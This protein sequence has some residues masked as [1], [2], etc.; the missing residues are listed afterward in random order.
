LSF[1]AASPDGS[2]WGLGAGSGD[3]LIYHYVSGSWTYVQGAASRLA[4]GPDGTPWAVTAAGNIY[5]YQNGTWNGIAGGASDIS[6]GADSSVY[7]VSNQGGGQYGYGIWHFAG[8]TWTQL[9]G[10]GVRVAASWDTG[11]YAGG[12]APGGFYLLNALGEIYYYTAANAYVQQPGT[13]SAIAPTTI[14]G[15]FSLSYPADTSGNGNAISYR[16]VATGTSVTQPGAAFGVSTNTNYAY[17]VGQGNV[18]YQSSVTPNPVTVPIIWDDSRRELESVATSSGGPRLTVLQGTSNTLTVYCTNCYDGGVGGLG[19]PFSVNWFSYGAP[20]GIAV[21]FQPAQTTGASASSMF[22]TA[23]WSAPPGNYN[24]TYYVCRV[25]I[26][27]VCSDYTVVDLIVLAAV[28]GPTG[29]QIPPAIWNQANA[30]RCQPG[31]GSLGNGCAIAVNKVLY[32]ALGHTI[33]TSNNDTS[34]LCHTTLQHP[35]FCQQSWV[36]DV[37][38]WGLAK[39]YLRQVAEQDAR[40]GDLTVQDGTRPAEGMQHI[41]FCESQFCQ[42]ALSNSGSSGTLCNSTGPGF[43]T[44]EP[45]GWLPWGLGPAAYRVL[46]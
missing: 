4:V 32:K 11:T 45:G 17:V 15:Y 37:I 24:F 5:Y 14:G 44:Q 18:A 35:H 29:D 1:V 40:A 13:A 7:V 25:D 42:S 6:V 3:T 16:D 22:V 43:S 33:P 34:Y 27:D 39:G 30:D 2:V 21:S 38:E 31:S 9:P 26:P 23:A 36:P 19:N 20:A 41:G 28:T 8:G 12:I 10:A 46:K